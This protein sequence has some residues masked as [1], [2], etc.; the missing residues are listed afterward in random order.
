MRGKQN[1]RTKVPRQEG[2]HYNRNLKVGGTAEGRR[3]HSVGASAA[4]RRTYC[5]DVHQSS[6]Y[7]GTLVSYFHFPLFKFNYLLPQK[8]IDVYIYIYTYIK[9]EI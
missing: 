8:Y 4:G 5:S 1:N 9:N 3:T 2:N 6:S 7:L